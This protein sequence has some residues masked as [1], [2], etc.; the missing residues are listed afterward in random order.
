MWSKMLCSLPV[1]FF[2]YKNC[3]KCFMSATRNEKVKKQTKFD[4]FYD[5]ANI[6]S[7]KNQNKIATLL[8]ESFSFRR[9][10][11]VKLYP[12]NNRHCSFRDESCGFEVVVLTVP[13]LHKKVN[14]SLI[15]A[16]LLTYKKTIQIKLKLWY[17]GSGKPFIN[18]CGSRVVKRS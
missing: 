12:E 3:F 5:F 8:P 18:S 11:Y 15:N 16:I 13:E 17:P 6:P 1:W 14:N 4:F 7:K 10:L 2:F 9:G